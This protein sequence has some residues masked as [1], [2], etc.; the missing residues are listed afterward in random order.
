[1]ALAFGLL[2]R[3]A[4]PAGPCW[5]ARYSSDCEGWRPSRVV[6]VLVLSASS[7]AASVGPLPPYLA[8][9]EAVNPNMPADVLPG[10]GLLAFGLPE[11]SS[12]AILPS[13]SGL[14]L[15]AWAACVML[16]VV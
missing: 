16:V 9:V 4:A 1:M 3:A 8:A 6:M 2:R 13:V 5:W 7:W 10:A 12:M 15:R 14:T 11:L